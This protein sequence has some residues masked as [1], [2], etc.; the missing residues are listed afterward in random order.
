MKVRRA[1]PPDRSEMLALWERSVRATHHFL[2]ERDITQLRP[3]VAE[4]FHSGALEF[5]VVVRSCDKPLGFLGY[6]AH[7]VEALFLDPAHRGKGAGKLLLAH[8][9]ARS[10][11]ALSVNVNEQNPDAVGFYRAQGFEVVS[12]SP[13]DADGRPFPTLHMRRSAPAAAR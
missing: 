8:A 6:R 7:S 9:Q 12:R 3:A 5:W 2:S 13:L 11:A 4:L 10:G 1:C